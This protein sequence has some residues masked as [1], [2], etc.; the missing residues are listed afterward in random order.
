MGN[1]WLKTFGLTLL[2]WWRLKWLTLLVCAGGVWLC[3]L[4]EHHILWSSVLF[5]CS[6]W[7]KQVI[8]EHQTYLATGIQKNQ[9]REQTKLPISQRVAF[10]SVR[11]FWSVERICMKNSKIP[12]FPNSIHNTQVIS[13]KK[14]WSKIASDEW[15][16][17]HACMLCMHVS[18]Q[19]CVLWVSLE[20]SVYNLTLINLD[21]RDYVD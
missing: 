7:S 3:Y 16:P 2:K 9:A 10:C 4:L 11:F 8:R 18:C 21:A 19:P 15:C 1:T 13:E 14:R 12:C 5:W 17:I 20:K 6:M